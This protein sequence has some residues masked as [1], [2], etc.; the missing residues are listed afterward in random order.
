ME[1]K[2]KK[3]RLCFENC[4]V[5]TIYPKDVLE[6]FIKGV[7]YDLW[8]NEIQYDINKKC[9]SLVLKLNKSVLKNKTYFEVT[10]ADTQFSLMYHLK[11]YH[12]IT[13]I[14]IV[15][16][17]ESSE[18]IMVPWKDTDSQSNS[19]EKVTFDEDFLL[20]EINKKNKRK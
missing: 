1:P 19:F 13:G 12:D 7:S 5:V 4:N 8:L 10:T 6:L 14:E 9:K 20:V 3:I 15:K 16:Q 2:Y 17:D 11:N 18:Y